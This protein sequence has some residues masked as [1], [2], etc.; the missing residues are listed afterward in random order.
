MTSLSNLSGRAVVAS[1]ALVL[2]ASGALAGPVATSVTWFAEAENSGPITFNAV[3]SAQQVHNNGDGSWTYIGALDGSPSA[4]GFN[5]SWGL[6]WIVGAKGGTPGAIA[7]GSAAFVTAD[8]EIT[9]FTAVSQT[10]FALV[11]VTLDS[12]IV[13]G[14]FIS[15]SSTAAVNGFGGTPASVYNHTS[16]P[17]AGDPV[18]AG[19]INGTEVRTMFDALLLSTP[20][21]PVSTSTTFGMPVPEVGPANANTISVMLKLEV[22]AFATASITGT[23]YVEPIPAPAGLPILAAGLGMLGFGRRR[24]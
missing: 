5:P 17:F 6:N 3:Q 20:G 1:S 22:S 8:L 23:F 16:G 13:G 24:R 14:T 11:T 19:L 9:N 15:G 10:F 21:G 12:P 2:C 7:G 18:Y 4:G